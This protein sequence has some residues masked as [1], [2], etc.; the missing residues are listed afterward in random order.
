MVQPCVSA[1]S[2]THYFCCSAGGTGA[3]GFSG[4]TGATGSTGNTGVHF[5]YIASSVYPLCLSS[6]GLC[7]E[8]LADSSKSSSQSCA[9]SSVLAKC[10]SS[11]QGL[12]LERN[13]DGWCDTGFSGFTGGTGSTG[14]TGFS[15]ETGGC[16][17]LFAAFSCLQGIVSIVRQ[18]C[19]SPFIRV[20]HAC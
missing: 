7:A 12:S 13:M 8:D 10:D 15:G 18:G 4:A 11:L 14:A 9:G 3:T 20:Q 6:F 2:L 5:L 17:S 19:M 1:A 16:M